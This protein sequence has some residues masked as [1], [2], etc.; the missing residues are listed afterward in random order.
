MDSILTHDGIEWH[1]FYDY[2]PPQAETDTDPPLRGIATIY[3]IFVRDKGVRINK[4]L[5]EHINVHTLH[6]LEREIE[7]INEEY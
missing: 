5:I 4:D 2:D 6:A 1:C 3:S 7:D